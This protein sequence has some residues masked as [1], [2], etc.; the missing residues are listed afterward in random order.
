M[1]KT[2][3]YYDNHEFDIFNA[4]D[5]QYHFTTSVTIAVSGAAGMRPKRPCHPP[6][7]TC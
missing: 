3:P 5:P 1:L 7:Q 2:C 6:K 4:G